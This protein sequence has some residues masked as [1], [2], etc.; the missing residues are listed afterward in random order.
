MEKSFVQNIK[1]VF[2]FLYKEINPQ[3]DNVRVCA[4]QQTNDFKT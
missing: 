4:V 2:R 3:I 1:I